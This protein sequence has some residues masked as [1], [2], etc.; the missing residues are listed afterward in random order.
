M[1][2]KRALEQ[3]AKLAAHLD[4]LLFRQPRDLAAF[5][6]DAALLRLLEADE[7]AQQRAFAAA[8]PA[9]DDQDFAALDAKVD[10]V[11]HAPAAVD[12]HQ[13]LD[14]DHIVR[15]NRPALGLRFRRFCQIG[16]H[17]QTKMK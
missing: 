3:H 2:S 17:D 11:E 10:A 4:E 6:P 13:V 12:F 16:D 1:L 15:A 14:D 8:R 5:E 9:H 7:L